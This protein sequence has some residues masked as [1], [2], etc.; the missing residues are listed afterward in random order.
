MAMSGICVG[1]CGLSEFFIL[2]P[3]SSDNGWYLC[4]YLWSVNGKAVSSIII[5]ISPVSGG[6]SVQ[7]ILVHGVCQR[8]DSVW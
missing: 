7:I 1:I 4:R 2:V 6:E 8:K 3:A 5:G